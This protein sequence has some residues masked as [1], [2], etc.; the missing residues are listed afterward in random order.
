M[1][2]PGIAVASAVAGWLNAAMLFAVLVRRGHWGKDAPLMKRI[3]RLVLSSVL[4]GMALW[5][6]ARWLGPQLASSAPLVTKAAA[7]AL[8]CGAGALVYFILAF[9]TGGAD[10][11]MLRRNIRRGPAEGTGPDRGN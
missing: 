4:M 7:T 1:G 2:A 11:G 3:P 5:F 10:L 8:L 6:G 9:A